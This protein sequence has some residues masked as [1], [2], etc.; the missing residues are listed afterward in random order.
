MYSRKEVSFPLSQRKQADND[1]ATSRVNLPPENAIGI[2]HVVP[3][4]V[5][6]RIICI[7]TYIYNHIP[8][9]EGLLTPDS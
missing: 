7:N 8:K 3:P 2:Y 5:T 9:K 6:M 4:A 1:L